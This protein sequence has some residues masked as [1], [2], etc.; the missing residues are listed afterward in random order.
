MAGPRE[1]ALQTRPVPLTMPRV[2][3][4]APNVRTA[5]PLAS[6]RRPTRS[7]S[8][9]PRR[10]AWAAKIRSVATCLPVES[11]ARRRGLSKETAHAGPQVDAAAPCQ[12]PSPAC[13]ARLEAGSRANCEPRSSS[14]RA[15]T[16][17]SRTTSC[18]RKTQAKTAQHRRSF[19]RTPMLTGFSGG[20]QQTAQ[21]AMLSCMLTCMAPLRGAGAHER[22]GS[23]C[24]APQLKAPCLGSPS[25]TRSLQADA[26]AAY[27]ARRLSR[28]TL[29]YRATPTATAWPQA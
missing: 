3:A 24:R 11:P 8:R 25:T 20:A 2:P 5:P 1:R 4:D 17:R 18:H 28:W 13:A 7:S 29:R 16:P 10:A 9:A 27:P 22:S 14:R 6:P 21:R 15:V 12:S 19:T 26:T 23:S